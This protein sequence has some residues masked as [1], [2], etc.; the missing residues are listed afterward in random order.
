[1]SIVQGHEKLVLAAK[2]LLAD[3]QVLKETWRDENC[4][5]FE[6]Q[7]IATLESEIRAA[8]LAMDRAQ[9]AIYRARQDCGDNEGSDA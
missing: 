7:Y 6:D 1:M 4:R 9:A 3:W 5:Q 2:K 8:A